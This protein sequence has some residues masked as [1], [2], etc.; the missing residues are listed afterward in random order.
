MVDEDDLNDELKRTDGDLEE[1]IK[2]L[3]GEPTIYN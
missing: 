2:N 1:A 3:Y